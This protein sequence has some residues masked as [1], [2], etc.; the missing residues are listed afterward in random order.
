MSRR[1]QH[2]IATLEMLLVLPVLLVFLAGLVFFGRYFTYYS[3]AQKA[4]HDGA[5]YLATVSR[6][7]MKTQLSGATQVPALLLAQ[8]IAQQEMA[9]LQAGPVAV[10]VECAP[11]PCTGWVL[12]EKV[13]VVVQMQVTDQL[14]AP[15]SDLFVGD[16][17]LLL[18]ADVSMLYVGQ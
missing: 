10:V 8:S 1:Y 17:G 12:P 15:F 16:Q 3:M 2:G 7:E 6:R 14:F 18:Q 13:R 11:G 9:G 4:A 5:R